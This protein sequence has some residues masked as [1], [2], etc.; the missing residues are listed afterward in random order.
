[1]SLFEPAGDED[2]QGNFAE[3]NRRARRF[4][5]VPRKTRLTVRRLG[6]KR[7]ERYPPAVA[8]HPD[9]GE[10]KHQLSAEACLSRLFLLSNFLKKA[11]THYEVRPYRGFHRRDDHSLQ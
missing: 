4:G 10:R 5:G 3:L 8:L 2:K 7:R 11:R 6:F 9:N 1:M